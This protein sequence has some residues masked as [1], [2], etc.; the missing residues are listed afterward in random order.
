MGCASGNAGWG[1]L[2]GDAAAECEAESVR[3]GAR[4]VAG[5]LPRQLQ[6]VP[7]LRARVAAAGGEA[8]S[9]R[10]GEDQYALLRRQAGMVH[11]NGAIGAAACGAA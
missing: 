3:G 10:G 5:V 8:D 2:A 4:A 11:E 7:V 6:L 1:R 9:L